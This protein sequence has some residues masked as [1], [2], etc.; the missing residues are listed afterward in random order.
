MYLFIYRPPYCSRL[1][2]NLAEAAGKKIAEYD[3]SAMIIV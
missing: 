2:Y 1:F 3:D